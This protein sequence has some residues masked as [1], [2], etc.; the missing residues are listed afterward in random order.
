MVALVF[1]CRVSRELVPGKH[2]DTRL[3]VRKNVIYKEAL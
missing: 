2:W 3:P 1:Q